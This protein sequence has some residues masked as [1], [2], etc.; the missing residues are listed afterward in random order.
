MG[1][2]LLIEDAHNVRNL[3]EKFFPREE[4][5]LFKSYP[6][7]EEK[8]RESQ[9]G[10]D[11]GIHP[12]PGLE[13]AIREYL[14]GEVEK[15]RTG[16]IREAVIG[17]VERA[18]IGIILEEEKGNQVKAAKRLGI[19]RNTLRKKIRELNIITRVITR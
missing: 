11:E 16:N 18:L 14:K 1:A 8:A 5:R 17:E 19:N 15:Q 2:V 7:E 10:Q 4:I 13:E 9:A 12:V 3:L 6:Q